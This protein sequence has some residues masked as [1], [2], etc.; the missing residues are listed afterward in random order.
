MRFLPE[1]T[2]AAFAALLSLPATAVP[3]LADVTLHGLFTDHMVLQRDVPVPVHGRAA[4]GEQVTVTFASQ[5]LT[6]K[7]ADDG[8]W[9][10]TLKPMKASTRPAGLTVE[11]KNKISLQDIVLGDV[12]VCSGQSNMEW[13]MDLCNRPEDIQSADLPLLRQFHVARAESAEPRVDVQSSWTVSS[14]ATAGKFTAVGFHFGRKILAETGVPVG[15]IH[16]AWGGTPIEPWI[17]PEAQKPIP[18]GLNVPI[19]I[20]FSPCKWN[21]LYNAMIHPLVKNPIK[22]VIWYQGESNAIF[23]PR[24]NVENAYLAKMQALV[25]GWR[26]AW[27]IGDFPF[28]YVQLATNEPPTDDPSGGAP[29]S[30]DWGKVCMAQMKALKIPNTGMAV[31]IDLADPANT[32]DIHPKNKVD[33]GDRLARWALTRDYGKKGLTYSGPLY[34]A[35][36]VEGRKIRIAFDYAGS[37]LMVGTKQ[38]Y[39]PVTEN[40]QAKLQRFAIAGEDRKWVWADAVIDGKTVVVSSPEVTKPVAV[41]YAFAANPVGCNL[42]NKEG[43]PASP[44]RTDDW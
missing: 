11:G 15:L 16:T 28:Y 24:P 22:G 14:P 43:L 9:S 17:T 36:R 37:G 1:K 5:R 38:G 23:D 3:A 25:S 4:P 27:G 30:V 10:V 29:K 21:V 6:T 2:M 7:A 40:P 35:M 44:F 20:P 41:R 13:T 18:E 33:V 8:T 32:A 19:N 39:A 26:K 31:A 12:W 42:Y 34:K